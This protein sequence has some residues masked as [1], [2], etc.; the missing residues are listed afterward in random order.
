MNVELYERR[1]AD[2]FEA[3]DFA[4]L[5]DE[6]I[7]RTALEAFAVHCP[8]ATAFADEL[9]LIVRMPM[10]SR[11]GTGFPIEQEYRNIRVALVGSDK[12]M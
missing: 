7:A 8:Y 10:R 3:V 11:A 4:S 6:D 12:L 2:S 9:D 5:D 1:V